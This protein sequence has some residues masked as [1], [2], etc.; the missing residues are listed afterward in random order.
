MSFIKALL[1]SL[2]QIISKLHSN[3]LPGTPKTPKITSHK[4]ITISRLRKSAEKGSCRQT[5]LSLY[6]P[7]DIRAMLRS[8]L[9]MAIILGAR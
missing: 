5:M 9:I 8:W 4:I 7:P 6:F 3:P 1:I 2:K